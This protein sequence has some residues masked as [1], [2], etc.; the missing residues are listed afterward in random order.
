MFCNILE[1]LSR[2]YTK[3]SIIDVPNNVKIKNNILSFIISPSTSNFGK[4]PING[5]MPP[6]LINMIKFEMLP[7]LAVFLLFCLKT[8]HNVKKYTTTKYFHIFSLKDTLKIIHLILEI[9]EKIIIVFVLLEAM[10]EILPT[11]AVVAHVKK[12][13]LEI[14]NL[15]ISNNKI[16]KI[17]W[18]VISIVIIAHLLLRT[19]GIIHKWRG[20]TPILNNKEIKKIKET[21]CIILKLSLIKIV[22]IKKI[23]L[24]ACTIK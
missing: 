11:I 4:N 5:G 22:S 17:F 2:R 3:I 16:G 19:T 20:A 7:G 18:I 14:S 15:E 10:L 12:I 24:T 23:E 1:K 8:I 6:I 9:L 13:K 21:D